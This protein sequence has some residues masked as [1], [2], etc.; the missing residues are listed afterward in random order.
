M[1]AADT[2]ILLRYFVDDGAEERPVAIRFIDEF[3]S[4]DRPAW[5]SHVV[6]AEFAWAL[7]KRYGRERHEVVAA[8]GELINHHAV[9]L[10]DDVVVALAADAYRRGP[11]DFADYLIG[12]IAHRAGATTTYTFDHNAAKW[13]HFT[14]L[15]QE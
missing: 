7:R 14:R 6:V 3:C 12:S 9:A 4:P 1:I 5:V 13:Q 10:E 2:N 8:L 15:P 11:A